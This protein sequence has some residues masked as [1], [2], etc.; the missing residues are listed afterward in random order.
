MMD[1]ETKIIDHLSANLTGIKG[2]YLFGS[3]ADGSAGP[4]S[5][6]DI[7]VITEF[8]N[9]LNPVD[10]FDHKINL[11]GQLGIPVDLIDLQ[12]A[13]TDLRFVIISTA[14]RIYCSDPYFCDFFEMTAISMYQNLEEERKEII[15]AVKKRGKIYG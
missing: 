6:V 13:Q 10:L 2:I 11:S 15:E 1:L 7:A 4:D 9:R 5:D 3:R 8:S 12:N 14:K